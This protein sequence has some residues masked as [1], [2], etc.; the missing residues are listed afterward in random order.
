MPTW[1]RTRKNPPK[2]TKVGE[3]VSNSQS[4]ERTKPRLLMILYSLVILAT[5][6]VV[7]I[8][9]PVAVY[10]VF[11][12]Q[13][14]N[15]ITSAHLIRQVYFYIGLTPVFIPIRTTIG[16]AFIAY[17]CIYAAL[18]IMAGLQVPRL[19][20]SIKSGVMR[21]LDTVYGNP[22]LGA[23]LLFGAL[24][25]TT[26]IIDKIQSGVGVQVGGLSG[27][28]LQL[29]LAV[30]IAPLAEET[31]FRLV[32]IGVPVFLVCL[33]AFGPSTAIRSLWRPSAA[34]EP[35]PEVEDTF[36][37]RGGTRLKTLTYALVVLSSVLFGIGHYISGAGWGIGKI[38]EAAVAGVFLGYSYVRYGFHSNV[39]IHWS[40]NTLASYDFLSQAIWKIPWDSSTGSLL[41]VLIEKYLVIYALGAP[42]FGYIGYKFLKRV[43]GVG[44]ASATDDSHR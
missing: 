33:F 16:I 4:V 36:A 15:S 14:S 39:I 40:V 27:D 18:M 19:W 10:T 2:E 43:L 8:S 26:Y 32:L 11:F 22:L 1:S 5:I 25:F 20:S 24:Q 17:Y 37:R 38:T 13:L 28:P 3:P 23:I 9:I 7:A 21:G 29:F 31:G 41:S 30:I 12:T 34:W 44:R 6:L 35:Q 42:S